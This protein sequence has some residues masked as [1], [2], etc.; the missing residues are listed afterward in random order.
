[1]K[2]T[3]SFIL[4]AVLMLTL[5]AACGDSTPSPSP[6]QHGS[7]NTAPPANQNT[8]ATPNPNFNANREITV[9]SREAGSGTRGAFIEITGV[10]VSADGTTTDRTSPEAVIGTGGNAIMTNVAGDTFAIGYIS[11]GSVN[12][13]V[14]ALRVEGVAPT[15]ENILGGTYGIARPFI[16]ITGK[17]LSPVA[18]DFVNFIMSKGGQDRVAERGFVT[19]DG[20]APAFQSNRASGN[21]VVGGSTSVEPLMTRLRED[22]LAINPNATIEVHGTGSGAGITGAIDGVVDIGMSSRDIRDSE[23]E[24]L[25]QV[26]TIAVDGIAVIVNNDN[27][28]SDLTVEQ[29]Q[30]IFTGET[31]RWSA[32]Q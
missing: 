21:I 15:P 17:A 12:G 2:K 7:S 4:L 20:N 27:P 24:R 13:T 16:I 22:Y 32:V 19:V 18:Q 10:Q 5:L 3:L 8:P 14:K 23:R 11:A 28:L 26:I 29:I 25:D 30:K 6:A 31:T 1:M 9:V